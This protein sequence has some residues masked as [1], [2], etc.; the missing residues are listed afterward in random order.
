MG[1]NCRIDGNLK[2]W[3]I[4]YTGFD[5]VLLTCSDVPVC[6][7]LMKWHRYGKTAKNVMEG[8]QLCEPGLISV[9]IMDMEEYHWCVCPICEV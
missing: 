4:I 1:E 5:G 3:G 6:V 2:V 7:A 8:Y 9:G